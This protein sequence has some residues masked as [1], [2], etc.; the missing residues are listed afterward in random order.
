MGVFESCGPRVPV[1]V[2]LLCVCKRS[3]IFLSVHCVSVSISFD[4]SGV[5]M[6]IFLL[7]L[8]HEASVWW[9]KYSAL[10]QNC[11]TVTSGKNRKGLMPCDPY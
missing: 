4:W 8:L 10:V 1:S 7:C 11:N 6:C 9:M 5:A 3:G 2:L